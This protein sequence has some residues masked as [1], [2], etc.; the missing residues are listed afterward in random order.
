MNKKKW[1]VTGIGLVLLVLGVIV[2][3]VTRSGALA[4]NAE[5]S[6]KVSFAL[7][8]IMTLVGIVIPIVASVPEKK[9][10]D[11]RTLSMAALFA[12][13]IGRAHV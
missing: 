5:A 2:T 10:T 3:V 7:G 1:I 9:K 13:Q 12:A 4:E 8:L 11:V 6:N